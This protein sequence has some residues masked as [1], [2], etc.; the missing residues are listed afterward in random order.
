MRNDGL[1]AKEG[2]VMDSLVGAWNEFQKLAEQHPSDMAEFCDGIHRCQ[3]IL[4]MRLARRDYPKAY[5]LRI[6]TS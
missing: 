1:T 3:H 6:K 4:V 5:K 2:K